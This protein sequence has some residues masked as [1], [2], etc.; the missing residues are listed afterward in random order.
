MCKSSIWSITGP[1]FSALLL[2]LLHFFP[3]FHHRD[4]GLVGLLTSLNID[5]RK[6]FYGLISDNYHTHPTVTRIAH[7]ANPHGMHHMSDRYPYARQVSIHQ[8][9]IHTSD[10]YPYAR[11]VSIHQTGIHT[12]DRYPY[13]R[14]VSIR[15]TG[16]HT[17]D[18]YPYARQVSI[19]QIGV[20]TIYWYLHMSLCSYSAGDRRNGCNGAAR[21]STSVK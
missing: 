12:P 14:Q 18:R 5:G 7:K 16:I 20:H 6:V 2:S 13:A 11:Q 15:Q 10:R 21:R 8:T 1:S 3:Q 4:P 17:P 19:H 9:G